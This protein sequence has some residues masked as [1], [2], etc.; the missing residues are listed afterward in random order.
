MDLVQQRVCKTLQPFCLYTPHSLNFFH[1]TLLLFNFLIFPLSVWTLKSHRHSPS[2]IISHQG[3]WWLMMSDTSGKLFNGLSYHESPVTQW[4]SIRSC[5][6]KVVASTPI[7]STQ[8]FYS[9]QPVSPTGKTPLSCIHQ[10]QNS[11]SH[12][13]HCTYI[14]TYRH[15]GRGSM[16][17]DVCHMNSV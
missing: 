6:Q 15:P 12:F 8:A 9:R 5:N 1:K 13:C 7:W 4:Q 3:F 17:Q 14:N 2:V 16:L 10:A 11:S